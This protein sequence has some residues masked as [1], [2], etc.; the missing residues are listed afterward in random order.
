MPERTIIMKKG[1]NWGGAR[2]GAGRPRYHYTITVD[3][4]TAQTYKLLIVQ[5]G[6]SYTAENVAKIAAELAEAAWQEIDKDYQKDAEWEG[7]IL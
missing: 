6:W 4:A 2:K 5:R 7:Q 3:R 1:E